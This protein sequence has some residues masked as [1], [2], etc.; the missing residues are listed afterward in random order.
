MSCMFGLFTTDLTLA[1]LGSLRTRLTTLERFKKRHPPQYF[2]LSSLFKI[3]FQ[4]AFMVKIFRTF[5]SRIKNQQEQLLNEWQLNLRVWMGVPRLG[6]LTLTIKKFSVTVNFIK[7]E[8]KTAPNKAMLFC[9]VFQEVFG[10]FRTISDHFGRFPKMSE[11]YW[12]FPRRNSV[13]CFLTV[14]RWIVL[15][16]QEWPCFYASRNCRIIHA[17]TEAH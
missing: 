10:L 15:K 17:S 11:N 3:T 7:K 8:T 1:I 12:S 9:S 4:K 14:P 16:G 13:R 6:I 5:F 2:L